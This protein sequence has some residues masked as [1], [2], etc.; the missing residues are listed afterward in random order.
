MTGLLV[1]NY[2]AAMATDIVQGVRAAIFR[3]NNDDGVSP[4][5]QCKVISCLRNLAGMPSK[6]PTRPPDAFNVSPVK[7]FVRIKLARQRPTW[8]ATAEERFEPRLHG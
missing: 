8:P 7:L 4:H 3:A 2:G 5:G 6:Q 1:A